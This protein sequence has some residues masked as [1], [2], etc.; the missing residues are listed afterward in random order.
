MTVD[1]DAYLLSHRGSGT[2]GILV[3]NCGMQAAENLH[4]VCRTESVRA[5]RIVVPSPTLVIEALNNWQS[6]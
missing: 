5:S 2:G 3:L 4:L 6:H 1:A